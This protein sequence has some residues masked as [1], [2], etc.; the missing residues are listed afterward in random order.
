MLRRKTVYFSCYL[1]WQDSFPVWVNIIEPQFWK[2]QGEKKKIKQQKKRVV[3][4]L[5][6][7]I[8]P[9]FC[10][11]CP[12][13]S[14]DSVPCADT[15]KKVR[16]KRV[17]RFDESI[18]TYTEFFRPYELTSFDDTFCI[19]MTNSAR[20]K[21]KMSSLYILDC[22]YF[23]SVY[24]YSYLWCESSVFHLLLPRQ[25]QLMALPIS[26]HEG[27]SCLKPWEWIQVHL[28][29]ANQRRLGNLCWGESV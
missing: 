16:V 9:I 20:W 6:T 28:P 11:F 29:F 22:G 13:V 4:K 15:M 21:T 23:V 19:T 25:R 24:L 17:N 2:D 8:R 27:N 7:F 26:F 14:L 5:L 1:P 18:D 12:F 3:V 10:P